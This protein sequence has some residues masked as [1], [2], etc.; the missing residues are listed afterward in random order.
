[1][2]HAFDAAERRLTTS[3][4]PALVAVAPTFLA[5]SEA[6]ASAA[7]GVGIFLDSLRDAENQQS[8]TLRSRL[9]DIER[10]LEAP[11]GVIGPGG[12]PG[13]QDEADEIRRQIAD[14]QS[15]IELAR[16]SPDELAGTLGLTRVASPIFEATD[17]RAIADEIDR[18]QELTEVARASTAE[19]RERVR[20]QQ[21]LAR[22]LAIVGADAEGSALALELHSNTLAAIAERASAAFVATDSFNRGVAETQS[23]IESTRTP[24]EGFIETESRLIELSERFPDAQK[25]D[26]RRARLSRAGVAGER[27]CVL[28]LGAR[29]SRLSGADGDAQ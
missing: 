28:G 5:I 22:S 11:Q 27:R 29:Q 1:M 15:A 14:R 26:Q 16:V 19:D 21:E 12:I 10:I 24:L 17:P 18:L 13:L 23:I 8:I 2:D 6:T 25:R 3:F 4:T 7:F 9:E 20:A